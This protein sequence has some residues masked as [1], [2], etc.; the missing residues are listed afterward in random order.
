V[1]GLN[2]LKN[3]TLGVGGGSLLQKTENAP[4]SSSC[5]LSWVQAAGDNGLML[6]LPLPL[7]LPLLP[8][9]GKETHPTHDSSHHHT[10]KR[11]RMQVLR[12]YSVDSDSA[13]G[14]GEYHAFR[15]AN[16]VVRPAAH[17]TH[18]CIARYAPQTLPLT[19]DTLRPGTMAHPPRILSSPLGSRST[20]PPPPPP[21]RRRQRP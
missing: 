20:T 3:V 21:P 17:V 16:R 19:R 6:L 15:C 4:H 7:P 1:W 14:L 8:P 9:C 5:P 10:R 12:V 13:C 11:A 2:Q 18:A